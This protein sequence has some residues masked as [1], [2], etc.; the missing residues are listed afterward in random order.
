M[1]IRAI[2]FD[3]AGT[4]VR[5]GW[6]PGA[7]GV[8]CLAELGIPHDPQ[9]AAERYDRLFLSRR[10]EFEVVNASRDLKL[11]EHYWRKLTSDWMA[12]ID[13]PPYRLDDVLEVADRLLYS[14]PSH[15]FSLYDDVLPCLDRL[16]Q[17]ELKLA[18]IS[19]WD[20]S[21]HRVV[22]AL[23]VADRFEFVLASL[24]EGVEKPDRRLFEVALEKLGL[25]PGEVL[26]VGDDPIDDVSGALGAGMQALLIDRRAA[27]DRASRR[28]AS[29]KE[30]RGALDWSA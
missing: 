24:E 25:E 16:A 1:P 7:F 13:V 11:V 10:T 28:I 14:G 5:V 29:L 23:G 22:R 17:G 15:Y 12:S 20:V 2:T 19:N 8:D 18:V 26:H 21:L 30:I 6:Q 3:A 9:V 27:T 4:L